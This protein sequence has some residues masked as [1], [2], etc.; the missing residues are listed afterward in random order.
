MSM[1]LI[2]AKPRLLTTALLG[3]AACSRGIQSALAGEYVRWRP[4]PVGMWGGE[5]AAMAENPGFSGTADQT[6]SPIHRVL[7]NSG[8]AIRLPDRAKPLP[9]GAASGGR[10]PPGTFGGVAA[11]LS[12][13][14]QSGMDSRKAVLTR[15]LQL[16]LS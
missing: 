4:S 12:D 8:E 7:D 13:P 14:V 5:V 1:R 3:S 16:R 2:P 11:A 6:P 10:L 15:A 9:T